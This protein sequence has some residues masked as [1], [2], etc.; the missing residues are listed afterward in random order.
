MTDQQSKEDSSQ[1]QRLSRRGLIKGGGALAVGAGLTGFPSVASAQGSTPEAGL[2][3]T[4]PG[5]PVPG[6][7]RVG[8][9]EG[10]G[11]GTVPLRAPAGLLDF[12][13]PNEYLHNMEVISFVEGI[14]ISGGEPLM[15]MWAEGSHRLIAAGTGFLDVSDPKKPFTYGQGQL[16]GQKI[17]VYSD[18]VDKWL[19]VTSHQRPLTAPNPQFPRGQYHPEYAQQAWNFNGFM[20]I[21]VYD[22]TDPGNVKL[23]SEFNTGENGH[24]THHNFYDGGKFAYL[25]CGFDDTLRM[26]SSERVL[27]NGV[28]IV[29]MS[30][31]A[32]VREVSRWWVPGQRVGEEE[33]YNKYPFAGDQ[34]SWTG[35]HGAMT[36]P[37]RVEDGGTVGYGGWGRFGMYVH[38]LSDIKNPKVYGKFVHPLENAGGIPYHTLY[39]TVVRPGTNPH[40]R[41][42]V[43]G[44]FEGL[45]PDGR[46]PWHTSYVIDVSDRRNPRL[47]GI[48]PRPMPHPDAP[49]DDFSQARGRFSAHNCQGWVAPGRMRPEIIAL[50][51]FSAGL[52]LYDIS[53][54]SD[55]TE[56]AYFV[57]ARIGEDLSDYSTWRRGTAETVV[58]E[59]D[60]NLI[61]LGTRHGTYCLSSPALG[62]P[63]LKPQPVT[64]WSVP[65]VNRATLRERRGKSPR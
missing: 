35:N 8:I 7:D 42:K 24:G 45:E 20:G 21:R 32:N 15:T 26:E 48:F 5:V 62:K 63:V 53:N 11:G 58:I 30:D 40:L 12:L 4:E 49:Y 19:V 23:L 65:H 28:M 51:Y 36:V 38:D 44:V 47:D 17:V 46:E 25:D 54:P 41:N 60:R 10:T 18:E 22:A 3:T 50:T 14:Q 9:I 13:D 34:T 64:E 59:W 61:W 27:G 37:K 16:P 43:I 33:E 31:P 56:V 6:W 29:D 52:R 39:P 1:G 55:P 57:P 2:A